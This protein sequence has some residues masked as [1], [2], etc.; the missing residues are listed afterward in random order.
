MEILFTNICF[1]AGLRL[2]R[3]AR[4]RL[5]CEAP[6]GAIGRK[7]GVCTPLYFAKLTFS[8]IAPVET[9]IP[10]SPPPVKPKTKTARSAG[11]GAM[12]RNCFLRL[13]LVCAPHRLLWCAVFALGPRVA[14]VFRK[15]VT[16]D[17]VTYRSGIFAETIRPKLRLRRLRPNRPHGPCRG[18][19]TVR[20]PSSPA[21]PA[22]CQRS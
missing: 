8:E 4:E 14:Q 12:D 19:R 11:F 21:G 3:L 9:S 6:D 15:C 20:C 10:Q 22:A 7:T 2:E 18:C 1:L 5:R 17:N 13:L 16:D